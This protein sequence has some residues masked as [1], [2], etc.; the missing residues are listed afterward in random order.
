MEIQFT[1]DGMK[2]QGAPVNTTGEVRWQNTMNGRNHIQSVETDEYGVA[3]LEPPV[4]FGAHFAAS[5]RFG[6]KISYFTREDKYTLVTPT[7]DDVAAL[8]E[9]IAPEGV[10]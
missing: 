10:N 3:Q 6:S 5:T 8:L 7:T 4:N 2:L 9:V 1:D